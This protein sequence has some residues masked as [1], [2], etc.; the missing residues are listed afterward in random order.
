[1]S[2][3]SR[4]LN[5]G[6]IQVA[7]ESTSLTSACLIQTNASSGSA[8]AAQTFWY[9]F[10]AQLLNWAGVGYADILIVSD[11]FF[12]FVG[13]GDTISLST[14]ARRRRISTSRLP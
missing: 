6:G 8:D 3:A 9:N 12:L 11:S 5:L 10:T 1:M 2:F 4:L 14:S 7:N 13:A